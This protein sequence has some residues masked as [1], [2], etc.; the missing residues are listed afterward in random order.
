MNHDLFL[1][2][3][4]LILFEKV[5][6]YLKTKLK[7][8]LLYFLVDSFDEFRLEGLK[9]LVIFSLLKVFLKFFIVFRNGIQILLKLRVGERRELFT[10]G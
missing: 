10:I 6:A 9:R 8:V 7:I 1:A 2:I 3:S 5:K 4:F